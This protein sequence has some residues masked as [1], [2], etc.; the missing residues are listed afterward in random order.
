M[1]AAVPN[2][3]N[4]TAPPFQEGVG[5][6]VFEERKPSADNRTV[7]RYLLLL[8]LLPTSVA[9]ALPMRSLSS[10]PTSATGQVIPYLDYA[11]PDP[12]LL[13]ATQ[14][15][16]PVPND[17]AMYERRIVQLR[18]FADED[19][20][21]LSGASER[22]FL[23]FAC[24][25]PHTRTASLVLL[26]NGNL[27]A[28]WRMGE[29]EVGLQFYGGGSVQYLISREGDDGNITHTAQRGTF[30]DFLAAIEGAGV[31]RLLYE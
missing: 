24:T 21:E 23:D 30:G 31:G 1:T 15:V 6:L 27:R 8:G 2:M 11:V 28:V 3:R 5:K 25:E 29:Q 4:D 13:T 18:S 12:R 17:R 20:I 19:G 26:D 14:L 7:R 10:D 22:D 9:D 16:A